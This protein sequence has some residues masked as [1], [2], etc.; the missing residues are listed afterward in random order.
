MAQNILIVFYEGKC[1]TERKL[2]NGAFVCFNHPDF[3]GQYILEHGEPI[4]MVGVCVCLRETGQCVE[5]CDDC[6]FLQGD[7]AYV[8]LVFDQTCFDHIRVLH[9]LV[10]YTSLVDWATTVKGSVHPKSQ[11]TFL[12]CL[13]WYLIM[14]IILVLFAKIMT[15]PAVRT[16]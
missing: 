7:G 8:L 15:Y 6:P 4:R 2:K 13:F 9:Y 11:K 16:T 10:N 1:F 14:Q 12:T 5:L 3:K